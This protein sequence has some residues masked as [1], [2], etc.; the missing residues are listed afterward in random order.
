M[1]DTAFLPELENP[2][3]ATMA[4]HALTMMIAEMIAAPNST[5]R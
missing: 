4:F 2:A 1:R 5:T 3:M